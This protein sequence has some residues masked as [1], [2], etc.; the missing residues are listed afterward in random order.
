MTEKLHKNLR[1]YPWYVG[2][3]HA[4]FW[5]PVYF[6]FFNSKL[7]LS[8]V[9][10][11]AS[12]YFASVVVVEVP[13][14]WF[15]DTFGRK[16]TLVTAS[17]FLCIAYAIFI[18]ANSFEQ[19]VVAQVFLAAGIAFNSGSDTS[20]LLETTQALDNEEA[21]GP[22]EAKAMKFNFLGTASAA[23]L[24]GLAAI[25]DYRGAYILSLVGGIGLL[26]I[27]LNFKEPLQ[28]K[29]EDRDNFVK[30]IFSCFGLLRNVRLLWL[31][32][33]AV[34]MIVINHIPYEF[35]QPYIEVLAKE[36]NAIKLTPFLSSLH[37][38]LTMLVASWIAAHSIRIK[39]KI[40][41]GATLLSATGLQIAMMAIMHFFVSIPAAIA[42]LLRSCPRALMT[43]PLNVA[44][45]PNVPASKRATFLS[46][47]SLF[48]RLGYSATLAFFATK[49]GGT[50]EWPAIATMLGWGMW[51]GLAGF[52][53]LLISV[54]C[55]SKQ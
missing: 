51:C 49:A 38:T 47:Q 53:L 13:S 48:G 36:Y 2:L 46:L 31:S 28:N 40:G 5:L 21:Y 32:V 11:L 50:D 17:I 35:Y 37:L 14:G 29:T 44:V 43:A 27:T 41:T 6:L 10:Y 1:L 23:V 19:F 3:F 54:R 9:L 26:I 15:S 30:Q 4:Y 42:T 8:D 20:L 25:P 39:N 7:D 24:G 34:F 16:K 33:F 12:I 22:C 18:F 45:A 55:L 52:A